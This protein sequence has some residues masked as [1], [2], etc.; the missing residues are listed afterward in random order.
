MIASFVFIFVF[1]IGGAFFYLFP[2]PSKLQVDYFSSKYPIIYKQ[3]VFENEVTL[4][5][6]IPYV[7]YDFLQ[8]QID[9]TVHF[10]EKSN[11]IIITTK[12]KVVQIPQTELTGFINDE[13]FTFE[14]PVFVT[15]NNKKF[16][17]L[18]PLLNIYPLELHFEKEHGVLFIY[19]NSEEQIIGKVVGDFSIHEGRLRTK[20]TVTSPYTDELQLNE[21]VF[22]EKTV[23]DYFYI[24]KE[25]GIAG[26]IKREFIQMVEKRTIEVEVPNES[27]ELP[28]L[29]T[30]I[31]LTWEAVYSTN[32]RTSELPNMDGVSVVSPTWFHIKNG[33]GDISNLAS[34]EYINWAH[35]RG[36]HVW[37]LFSNGFDPDITHEA[38]SSFETRQKM[39]KQLVTYSSMYHL[40]GINVDFENVY[41]EDGPLVTQFMRELT[42]YLHQ[43]GLIVSMDVTFISSS[44]M[45][46]KF[47]EREALAD[48]VD[49][50][51]V[52][53]YDEHW[54]T[55]P[56]AGSVAS[57]P[58]VENH[59]KTILELIPNEKVI[60]GIP[61]YTRLWKEQETEGGNIE[62]SSKAL[63]MDEVN[64]WMDERN[65]EPQFD[66]VTGQNYVEYTDET[67]KAVYKIW[68]E[69]EVSL[70]KRVD[71]MNKY[72]LQGIASWARSFANDSAW[73][74]LNK[75]LKSQEK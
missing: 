23:D 43:A 18:D 26:Y 73:Q 71:L 72:S 70:Q 22:V 56:M 1:L 75:A 48:I 46:S 2:F 44:E 45:W 61:L 66:P 50:M 19:E 57:L 39:I 11:S 55:S 16:I 30:P 41:L 8:N 63:S 67:E 21:E 42:P 4:I 58:W 20:P 69:D 54:A 51:I 29:K 6:D 7:S 53:A 32:P 28:T 14:V 36:F 64:T 33:A 62:V 27:F 5:D 59:L 13:S 74:T 47:Y 49:Y 68:L 25:N 60:L 3:E 34:Y 24:R 17:H 38:L 65:I 35:N 40:E 12:D 9:P 15:E 37:A 10:D 52:M 31:H